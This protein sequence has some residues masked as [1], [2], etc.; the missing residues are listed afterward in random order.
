MRLQDYP[1]PPQ[2]NGIGMHWSGGNA[3]LVGAGELRSRWIPELQRLGVK[4]VKFLHDGGLEFA[5]LLLD[6][7][8]MPVVRVYR[9]RPNSLDLDKSTLSRKEIGSLKDYVSIGVKYFEFNNEPDVGSEWEGSAAPPNALDS[10]ARAALVD[11]EKVLAAGGYPAVPAM[12]VGNQWDFIGRMIRLAGRSLFDEPVWIAVH[13]YDINHPLDYP[14]DA[15]NQEGEEITRTEYDRLGMAAWQGRNWRLRSRDFVNQ[16][17]RKGVN[18]GHSV[19]DDPSCFRVYERLAALCHQHLGRY[20]PMLSTENGP[21]V[22]EDDD[23]RY[24]TTTPALQAEKVAEI[25]RIMMGVSERYPA[26][27]PYYF[28]TAFWLMGNAVLRG[29]GWE[30]HAWYSPTWPGGRLP[31]VEALAAVP[32]IPR[33]PATDADNGDRSSLPPVA[34]HSI[35]AGIMYDHPQ[36]RVILRATGSAAETM[37]DDSGAY[38]FEELPAGTYRLS[39]PGTQIVRSNLKVDGFNVLRVDV[40]QPPS[41]PPPPTRDWQ[42]VITDVGRS[43]GFGVIRVSVEGKLNL[44]VQIATTGWAGYA[45][46]TGSKTEHGPYALEFAPLSAGR[47]TITPADIGVKAEVVLDST[48]ALMVRFTP[49]TQ[50]SAPAPITTSI[51]S[52]RVANGAGRTIVLRGPAGDRS[53]TIGTDEMYRFENLGAGVYALLVPETDVRRDGLEMD[54]TNQRVANFALPTLPPAQSVIRGV[55]PGGA[56]LKVTL[57]GPDQ[58]QLSQVTDV[59]GQFSFT[60]LRDGAYRL[61]VNG[62]EGEATTDVQVDGANTVEVTLRLQSPAA[63]GSWRATVSDGGASP[64]FAVVR[65]RV[66]DH[67]DLPVRLWTDGWS[68]MVRRTGDKPEYGPAVCEFAPLGAGTYFVEPQ[69]LGT[70]AEIKADGR[71]VLWVTFTQIAPQPVGKTVEHCLL[72]GELPLDLA[73]YR[74]MLRYVARFRPAIVSTQSEAMVA[75]NVTLI[76]GEQALPRK[77]QD[78]L[79]KSGCRVERLSG[80]GLAAQLQKRIDAG[81][82]FAG[83]AAVEAKRHSDSSPSPVRSGQDF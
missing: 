2:D 74:V 25:A 78:A 38:R 83:S 77:I 46:L 20:L 49:P 8:M 29:V 1:R 15:V 72:I 57:R 24:P 31:A 33:L 80:P 47:Y 56:G 34:V 54:G 14:Y 82:A 7:G 10:A 26:A 51:I 12:A 11:M 62:A 79:V 36:H 52:G 16:Q 71:R 35:I 44:L 81:Q 65:V 59:E 69:G 18:S 76:G 21:I 53:T 39:V 4:W 63:G 66:E 58:Q 28:C 67:P 30:T 22:G 19:H 45:Q 41:P 55:V 48:R 43:P 17:R 5:Q 50:P 75:R 60:G 68:G 9:P 13:N 6:A 42:V 23:P 40:G 27:P 64:G 37:T 61:T 3:G 73:A 70:R 32:K